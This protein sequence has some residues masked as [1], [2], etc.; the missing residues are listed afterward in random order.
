DNVDAAISAANTGSG[1]G[2]AGGAGCT[3]PTYHW[4]YDV[5]PESVQSGEKTSVTVSAVNVSVSVD[6]TVKTPT[7]AE[8]N[9]ATASEQKTWDAMS[10]KLKSHEEGH[11]ERDK[12][13]AR[14]MKEAIK[15]TKETGT[16]ASPRQA[17]ADARKNLKERVDS[18]A[19]A[20]KDA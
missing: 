9:K 4:E 1:S 20:V 5:K 17:L 2:C 10:D 18:K 8:Y 3:T 14:E 13:G 6:I 15:G 16:G 11:V 12:A 19:N 7:W